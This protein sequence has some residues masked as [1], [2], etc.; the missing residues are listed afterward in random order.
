MRSL[1]YRECHKALEYIETSKASTASK[2]CLRFI[3]LT[4]ARYGEV[5]YAEWAE[6]DWETRLWKVPA[7]RMKMRR[8]HRVPLSDA[9]LEVLKR[10]KTIDDGS[11]LIFPSLTRPGEAISENTLT[12]LLKRIGIHDRAT[13]HGFR[14][15]FRNWSEEQTSASEAAKKL[16]L[17]HEVGSS[18]EQ[19]H[20]RSDLLGRRRDLMQQWA[21]YLA[22]PSD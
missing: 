14:S 7:S 4:A 5:R 9:S 8:P 17:A 22:M 3:I 12:M 19:A 18:V 15:S 11:G 13:V 10:A 20:M 16:S 1:P 21:D 6:V 2:L